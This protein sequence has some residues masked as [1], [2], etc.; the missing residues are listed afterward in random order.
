MK[1]GMPHLLMQKWKL[2]A[3]S[4]RTGFRLDG[5]N[6]SFTDKATDKAPEHGI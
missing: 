2:Q 5:P 6:L 1:K 4:D 3:R